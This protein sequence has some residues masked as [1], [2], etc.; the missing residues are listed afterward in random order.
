[1]QISIDTNKIP[2]LCPIVECK[3]EINI[4][5]VNNLLDNDYMKRFDL[6]SFKLAM[7][8]NA[9]NFMHCPTPDC[10]YV[11][12]ALKNDLKGFFKCAMCGIEY[13]LECEAAWHEG[14]TCND[15]QR[16]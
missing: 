1:M 8:K 11:C 3:A 2:L 7:H 13:C 5:S 12:F 4:N 9:Q 10:E 6:F 14:I 15:Y 16:Q